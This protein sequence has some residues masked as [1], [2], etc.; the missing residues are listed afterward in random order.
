VIAPVAAMPATKADPRTRTW[1]WNQDR[2]R[3]V[4]PNTGRL[5][6]E[7]RVF[8]ARERLIEDSQKRMAGLADSYTNGEITLSQFQKRMRREY[9]DQHVA[10]RALGRGGEKQ[11]TRADRQA[12]SDMIKRENEYLAG[13]ARDIADGKLT[14]AQIRARAEM[15]AG[16]NMRQEYAAAR[17]GSHQA[18]GY[19]HKRRVGPN[20]ASTCP[21]CRLEIAQEWVPIDAAGFELG[22][23]ECGSR[24]RCEIVFSRELPGGGRMY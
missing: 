17:L 6:P 10:M 14:P 22:H 3:Y 2:E 16:A 8:R 5:V 24:D 7:G 12:I 13:F 21:T 19:T 9:T 1:V 23:T 20:D 18:E 4:W 11:L 15:Y